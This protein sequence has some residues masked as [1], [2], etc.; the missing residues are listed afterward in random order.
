MAQRNPLAAIKPAQIVYSDREAI[1]KQLNEDVAVCIASMDTTYASKMADKAKIISHEQKQLLSELSDHSDLLLKE[2]SLLLKRILAESF[3]QVE[4]INDLKMIVLDLMHILKKNTPTYAAAE[5]VLNTLACLLAMP[6]TDGQVKIHQTSDLMRSL[7]SIRLSHISVIGKNYLKAHSQEFTKDHRQNELYSIFIVNRMTGE[8]ILE[9]KCKCNDLKGLELT[10]RNILLMSKADRSVKIFDPKTKECV[11]SLLRG[12]LMAAIGDNKVAI[13]N[14]Y[15]DRSTIC[16]YQED[17]LHYTK[18]DAKL[19]F[20]DCVLSVIGLDNHIIALKCSASNP[21]YLDGCL[22]LAVISK[23][24]Y[25]VIEVMRLEDSK[26]ENSSLLKLERNRFALVSNTETRIFDLQQNRINEAGAIANGNVHSV[27]GVCGNKILRS[28]Q[29]GNTIFVLDTEDFSRETVK[30]SV[31]LEECL[32]LSDGEM[33]VRFNG[34]PPVQC[35]IN[36]QLAPVSRAAL[37]TKDNASVG[38]VARIEESSLTGATSV[39]DAKA[40]A[41]P[42]AGGRLFNPISPPHGSAESASRVAESPLDLFRQQYGKDDITNFLIDQLE[43]RIK[44]LNAQRL[45]SGVGSG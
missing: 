26:F 31:F 43:Q 13:V 44:L 39:T 20:K 34:M 5:K 14:S 24:D 38:A 4:K 21:Y 32:F 25:R 29:Y 9:L 16:I 28:D 36:L 19:E 17:K 11:L 6:Q 30:L 37:E 41:G 40:F 27:H 23:N 15:H 10:N 45:A 7:A 35:Q 12:N 22:E 2:K 1:L 8:K 42:A 33:I 3:R 18:S